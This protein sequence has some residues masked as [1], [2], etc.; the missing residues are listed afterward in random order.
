MGVGF[1]PLPCSWDLWGCG[2]VLPALTAL[3]VFFSLTDVQESRFS[4]CLPLLLSPA[5]AET[6]L[7][8]SQ[9]DFVPLRWAGVPGAGSSPEWPGVVL[10]WRIG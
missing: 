5:G 9:M 1:P 3:L 10:Q 4:P 7:Q 2:A 6:F 8:G